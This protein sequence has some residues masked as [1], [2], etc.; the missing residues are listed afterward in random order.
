MTTNCGTCP[1]DKNWTFIGSDKF[2]QEFLYNVANYPLYRGTRGWRFPNGSTKKCDKIDT[3]WT[4]GDDTPKYAPNSAGL[5]DQGY[6]ML[7][8]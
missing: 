5:E 4:K 6:S 2:P 8:N 1:A 3:N 7:L